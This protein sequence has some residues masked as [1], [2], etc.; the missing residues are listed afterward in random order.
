MSANIGSLDE[1]RRVILEAQTQGVTQ[2]SQ[3]QG[4]DVGRNGE[5]F[6]PGTA[7]HDEPLSKTHLGT[8][9]VS[10][11]RREVQDQR[12]ASGH[13]PPNTRFIESPTARGWC[14]RIQTKLGNYYTLF[15]YFDGRHYQVS[16]I[17]PRLEGSIGVHNGHLYSDGRLCLSDD[18]DSGQPSLE[19]AYSKS[20]IWANGVDVVRLGW[21]FPYSVNNLD[22]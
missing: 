3:G 21:N 1:L 16:L 19:T 14:Y 5:I 11:A 12:F 10:A 7:P 22:D 9:A 20:V 15:A 8:F 18:F 17:E 2:P 6:T 4:V 13:L